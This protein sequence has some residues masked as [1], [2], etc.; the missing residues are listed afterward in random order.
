[1]RQLEALNRK[2]HEVLSAVANESVRSSAETISKLLAASLAV[3]RPESG[4][5]SGGG[6]KTAASLQERI[7]VVAKTFQIDSAALGQWVAHL[8]GPALKSPADPF[9]LWALLANRS[10]EL[11]SD[12]IVAFVAERCADQQRLLEQEQASA[13]EQMVFEDF[14][15]SAFDGWFVERDAFGAGPAPDAVAPGARRV[16]HSGSLSHRLEGVLRSRTFTIEKDHI[17][18]RAAGKNAKINLI[19]DSFQLIRAPIYGGLT[20]A[21]ESPDLMQRFAQDVSKWV[22]HNAYIELIDPGD[23]FLAVEAILF[24]DNNAPA[25]VPNPVTRR[26]LDDR[27]VESVEMLAQKYA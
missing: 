24:S 10:G 7:A 27:D 21:V 8:Q 2:E 17:L 4:D 6:V 26:L 23:G 11:S 1:V 3:L 5:A 22:G 16:A 13:R 14:S 15:K 18:Y 12:A 19:V 25:A 20:I 9:R